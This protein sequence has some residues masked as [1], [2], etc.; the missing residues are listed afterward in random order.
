M[1]ETGGS[2]RRCSGGSSACCLLRFCSDEVDPL[3]ELALQNDAFVDDGRDAFEQ[4]AAGAE[5]SVL[6]AGGRQPMDDCSGDA[7]R[8]EQTAFAKDAHGRASQ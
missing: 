4:L 5:L 7:R 3:G 1:T 6:C 2:G 8:R